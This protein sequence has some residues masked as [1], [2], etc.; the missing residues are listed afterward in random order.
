VH[1]PDERFELCFALDDLAQLERRHRVVVYGKHAM[2]N[3]EDRSR[4]SE[5]FDHTIGELGG[6]G[7]GPSG[8]ADPAEAQVSTLLG[9]Q[10][11][12][13]PMPRPGGRSHALGMDDRLHVAA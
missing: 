1:Q 5:P 9:E 4:F 8:N 12:R 11:E 3:E 6:T 7:G 13:F 2:A 10:C